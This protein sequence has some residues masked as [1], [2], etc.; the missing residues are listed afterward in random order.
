MNFIADA[1]CS[2]ALGFNVCHLSLS[3]LVL[4]YLEKGKNQKDQWLLLLLIAYIK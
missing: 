2:S 4:I 1:V 3:I